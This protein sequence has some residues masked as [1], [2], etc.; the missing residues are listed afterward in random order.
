MLTRNVTLFSVFAAMVMCMF[1]LA[2]ATRAA[3]VSET[4]KT[5]V[6]KASQGGM[7][8]VAAAKVAL[9]NSQNEKV[10]EFAQKMI[11]DH[12]K[13]NMELMDL[14]KTK[15]LEVPATLDEKHEKMVEKMKGMMGADFDK[16]YI[17]DMVKDHK[18]TVDLFEKEAA[19]GDDSSLKEWAS[20]TLPT[21]KEH[22]TMV[23]AMSEGMGMKDKMDHMDHDKDNGMGK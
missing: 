21:L 15:D 20:K 5:F 11:D 12:T 10:K 19:N 2:P 4:D 13:A 16:A 3:D 9:A 7:T 18:M 6:M 8:E 14:A 17:K 1:T 23:M 22:Q